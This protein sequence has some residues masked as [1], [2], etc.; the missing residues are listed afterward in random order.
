M[1]NIQDLTDMLDSIVF[2]WY[3]FNGLFDGGCAFAAS[4]IA[5]ELEERE[6]P[7]EVVCYHSPNKKRE[8]DIFKLADNHDIFHVGIKLN[9]AVLGGDIDDLVS[10]HGLDTHYFKLTSED[11]EKLYK[12]YEWNTKYDA[13]NNDD[14]VQ[15]IKELFYF[16]A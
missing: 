10:E 2:H 11:L 5:K 8:D 4:V 13:S 16:F 3:K 15:E 7:F 12:E 9:D 14:F 6:I 1:E